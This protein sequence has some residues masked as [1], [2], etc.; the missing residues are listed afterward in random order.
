M[1]RKFR[2][3]MSFLLRL[4]KDNI[5]VSWNAYEGNPEW[6]WPNVQQNVSIPQNILDTL[7][8]IT[9]LN[10]NEIFDM[11]CYSETDYYTLTAKILPKEK[12]IIYSLDVEEY[13]N[14]TETYEN[15]LE[16]PELEE[17]FKRTGIEIIEA[18]YSGG[19]DSGDIDSI[20]ID[21]EDSNIQWSSQDEDERLI[22][23]TLYDQL[24]NAYGGWEIDD[25]SAGTIELNNNLEIV[26]SHEW[27]MREMVDCDDRYEIT[28]DDL[29]E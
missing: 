24:E 4:K 26:I 29:E 18:R 7:V 27:N 22:W 8:D 10:V 16:N 19:G 28:E 1:K 2:M 14:E 12:K 6:E 17:Y 15:K 3:L 5:Q 9:D 21:G 11:D 20:K 23:N 13:K 25:G